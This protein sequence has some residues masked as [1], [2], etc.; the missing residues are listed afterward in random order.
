[1]RKIAD[2]TDQLKLAKENLLLADKLKKSAADFNLRS[3]QIAIFKAISLNFLIKT[4][5]SHDCNEIFLVRGV[6]HDLVGRRCYEINFKLGYF[7]LFDALQILHYSRY[8]FRVAI[9]SFA[10]VLARNMNATFRLKA[11]AEKVHF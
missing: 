9:R 10:I 6:C 1:M 7:D 8:V 3:F 11:G 4:Q 2:L 5:R